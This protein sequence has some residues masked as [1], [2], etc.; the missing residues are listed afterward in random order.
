MKLVR[1]FLLFVFVFLICENSFATHNR[2]GEISYQWIGTDSTDLTYK[3]IIVTYTKTSSPIDRPALDQVYLGDNSAPVTF[4][5]RSSTQLVGDITRNIYDYIHTYNGNGSFKISFVDPNRNE[6]VINIPNSVEVPFYVES[7]LVINPYL[8]PNS[9][10]VLTYP[11]IDH[12]C[13]G[14]IFIHNPGAHDPEGDSLTYELVPCGGESGLPIP[15]YTYP[16]ATHS[17]TLDRFTGDLIWDEPA[18]PGEYNVAFNVIQWKQGVFAGFVRRDMQI[19]IGTCSNH[20]PIIEAINDTCV[21]AGDTLA[22]NVTA[23]DPDHDR[24]E[25]SGY[26]AIFLDSLVPDPARL[27]R[28]TF[29]NDTVVSRF[30]WATKCHHVRYRPYTAIFRASDVQNVDSISLVDIKTVNIRVIAPAPPSV[31]V[32]PNG[33]NI[34]VN[35]S[36]SPCT[37]AK[38]YYVYRRTDLY[39]GTLQ[40]PCDNGVPSFTGYQR[41]ATINSIDT[42]HFQDTNNGSG[43]AIGVQYCYLVTAFF[44]DGSESCASPQACTTLKKDLPIL[45]NADVNSTDN[46]NGSIN[47][48]WSKPTEIDTIQYPGPYEYRLFH[49]IGFSSNNFIQ[50][51]TFSDLNDTVYVDTL[52]NTVANPWTYRVELYY[53]NSGNLIFKGAST[54][55]SSVFLSIAPTDNRLNLSWE[56]HTPWTDTAYVVYRFNSNTSSWDSLTTLANQQYSDTGLANGTQYCYYIKSIGSYSTPGLASPLYNRS[57]QK[58]EIP[59]DNIPPCATPLIVN[60]DCENNANFLQWVNPNHTCA[61]DVLKY[62]IYY[63]AGDSLSFELIDSVLN[64]Q[65]TTFL[66]SN[67]EV[68]S[69]CYKIVSVDSVGNLTLNPI[70]VCVDTCRQYVLPSVFTPNNDGVNDLFHPC[71]NTTSPALQTKNCPAYKNVKKVDMKIFNRWG[72]LVYETENK[73]VNWDGK[74]KDSKQ[75]CAEGVYYYTCKVYFYRIFGDDV[76]ELH[77]T[78]QLIRNK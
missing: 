64:P 6:G 76:K 55:S 73:D 43:L 71:D 40:C 78:I 16:N 4:N 48:I 37:E 53:T 18:S 61:D 56:E 2:A 50:L 62:Y 72:N 63:S 11:P 13:V 36:A 12:G 34:D 31:L 1:F 47:V 68:I 25:L 42:L 32:S 7:I 52:I 74:N 54:I 19:D 27:T 66:H 35:W 15:G 51:S 57:Q 46:V 33:S 24:V 22:F 58:C 23:I 26:G 10:P 20:P 30:S 17:F 69:G 65:D 9:S 77:G 3:I 38:G 21:L 60:S 41:I 44:A 70:I 8:G 59:I 39:S 5:R 49:A 45:T 14:R 67:L 29:N 75:D 28:I